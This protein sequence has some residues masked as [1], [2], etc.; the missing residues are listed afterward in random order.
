MKRNFSH[1]TARYIRDRI[2]VMVYEHKQPH[3]PWLTADAIA[4][5][6]ALL[7]QGD[8]GVEFGSG[9]STVWLGA[10]VHKLTSYENCEEWYK[11]VNTLITRSGLREKVS[12]HC[13][14]NL[15]EYASRPET[16]RD[17]SV[18][19][20]LVDGEVRDKCAIRMIPKIKH[21]GLLI[22]D[23]VNWYLPNDISVSPRSRRMRDGCES[24]VWEKFFG[25]TAAW[26]RVWTSNG[27]TD[28]C[29]FIK[30]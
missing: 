28:T 17:D 3:H 20:C 14:Q 15:E 16:Y 6:S 9:R 24:E 8:V 10:R 30:P 7:R 21:G 5:L 27:V 1:I 18:D 19:F 23:N 11:R 26:R 12:L 13:I 2:K 25:M 4:L 22:V 29:V